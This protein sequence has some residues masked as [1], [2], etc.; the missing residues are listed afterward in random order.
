[1][2][3]NAVE[4]AVL[5][6]G[7]D[8]AGPSAR[9]AS[10]TSRKSRR[11]VAAARPARRHHGSD[12]PAARLARH[13]GGR[14]GPRLGPRCR[15]FEHAGAGRGRRRRRRAWVHARQPLPR[16]SRNRGYGHGRHGIEFRFPVPLASDRLHSSLPGAQPIAPRSPARRDCCRAPQPESA[17]QLRL[18]SAHR[19]RRNDGYGAR[20]WEN[21]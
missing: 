15:E 4:F 13:R 2:F 10:T 3:H 14:A 21:A 19:A 16:R 9:R 5:Y 20:L 8:R 12:W 11:C 7:E 1:M 17:V 6:P 18:R